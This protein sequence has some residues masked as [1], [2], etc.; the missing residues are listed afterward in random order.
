MTR[1]MWDVPAFPDGIVVV[2]ALYA[3]IMPS[4]GGGMWGNVRGSVGQRWPCLLPLPA[5]CLPTAYC[6]LLYFVP[7]TAYSVLRTTV[8]PTPCSVLL[9]PTTA[10]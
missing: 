1:V 9:C 3:R 7:R 4:G 6:L 8:L 10:R 2:S 5:A